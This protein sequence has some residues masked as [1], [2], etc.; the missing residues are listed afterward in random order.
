[1]G[2]TSISSYL[3]MDNWDPKWHQWFQWQDLRPKSQPSYVI[4][5]FFEIKGIEPA[6]VEYLC[7]RASFRSIW[8]KLESLGKRVH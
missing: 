8:H 5:C 2:K 6:M 4:K 1:M 7:V 3:K